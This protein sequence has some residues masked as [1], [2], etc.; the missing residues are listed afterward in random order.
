MPS[1][2]ILCR[3]GEQQWSGDKLL[4]DVSLWKSIGEANILM[5]RNTSPLE[6]GSLHIE[7]TREGSADGGNRF[8]VFAL[9]LTAGRETRN[10][11]TWGPV[12]IASGP[13][14]F[15][16]RGLFQNPSTTGQNRPASMASLSYAWEKLA[17]TTSSFHHAVPLEEIH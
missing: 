8:C 14:F 3:I 10:P 16:T 12:C 15:S 6:R 11:R 5:H 17:Y 4:L 7:N 1:D 9:L 2:R 13:L